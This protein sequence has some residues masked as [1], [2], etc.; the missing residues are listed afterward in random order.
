MGY[1]APVAI[2]SGVDR[3]VVSGNLPGGE[4]WSCSFYQQSGSSGTAQDTATTM[5]NSSSTFFTNVIA[6]L[7]PINPSTVSF[8][9]IDVYRY[10]GGNAA[11]DKGSA[12]ISGT[13]GT[14][15]FL[16]PNQTCF[17]STLRTAS[18]TRR[19]RGRIFWPALGASMGANG[20]FVPTPLQS[21]LNGLKAYLV[22]SGA[23]FVVSSA[24]SQKRAITSIDADLVPDSQN[25][26]RRS[27][28][29]A[30]ITGV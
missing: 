30:R 21:L 27:L 23:G 1:A 7:T 18:P 10:T 5:A 14:S 6:K 4:K 9:R 13:N 22:G 26:R 16:N 20:L 28:S 17:V 15:S 11:S 29:A 25:G 8:L 24:D 12:S 3:I 2:P 19:G